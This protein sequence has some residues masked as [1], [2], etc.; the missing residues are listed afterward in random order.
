MLRNIMEDIVDEIIKDL[1]GKE[2]IKS[3]NCDQCK[4]D[5]KTYVL[6]HIKPR[7][8]DTSKGEAISKTD[9]LVNQVRTDIIEEILKAIEIISKNPRH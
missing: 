7:Y 9:S 4:L 3:C 2:K 6:N 1:L 5:I 8:V